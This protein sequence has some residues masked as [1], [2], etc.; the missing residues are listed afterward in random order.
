M[1]QIMKYLLFILL[2]AVSGACFAQTTELWR[3]DK[4]DC[5]NYVK[6]IREGNVLFHASPSKIV[7][8]DKNNKSIDGFSF[9]QRLKFRGV[10]TS[11][12]CYVMITVKKN[13][14]VTL[15]GMSGNSHDGPQTMQIKN[16]KSGQVLCPDF[17]TNDGTV[18]GKGVYTH[19]GE[20]ANIMIFCNSHTYNVYCIKI[21]HNTK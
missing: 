1:Y 4:L 14:V 16:V 12:G 7:T 19:V 8:V 3:A 5:G 9:S 11:T 17:L 18:I 20:D 10:G 2:C 13:D 6:P 15:Y 21:D